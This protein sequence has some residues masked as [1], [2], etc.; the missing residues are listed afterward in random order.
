MDFRENPDAMASL[1]GHFDIDSQ[2][3]S[4]IGKKEEEDESTLKAIE[5]SCEGPKDFSETH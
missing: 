2:T 5:N 4:T 1:L 3:L